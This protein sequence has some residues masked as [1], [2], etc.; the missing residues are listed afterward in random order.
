MTIV[1]T[2]YNRRSFLKN[3][4]AAG[5]GLMIGFSWLATACT[6]DASKGMTIPDEWFEI[7]GYLKIGD[8]GV[9]TILSPKIGRAHV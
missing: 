2:T 5:G 9:V 7:N 1:K 3:T 8:N 6:T 4:L